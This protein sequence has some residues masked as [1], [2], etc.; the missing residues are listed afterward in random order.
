MKLSCLIAAI[1]ICAACLATAQGDAGKKQMKKEKAAQNPFMAVTEL[2]AT[3][4]P[5]SG[6][7]VKGSVYFKKMKGMVEVVVDVSGLTPGSE[8]GF[9]IHNFGNISAPDGTSAGDHYNPS[10]HP[11]GLPD[12]EVRHAGDFGNLKADDTGKAVKSFTIDDISLAG[13]MNP[14]IGRSIVIHAKKDD[15]GQ[16]TG[17]AGPRIGVGVIG[18]SKVKPMAQ[19][20]ADHVDKSGDDPEEAGH[21]AEDEEMEDHGE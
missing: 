13:K 14:I 10:G 19:P 5:A 4:V 2:V 3:V 16:P 1:G 9:H 11:H 7:N 12:A 6:S 21:N 17:N 8:H 20:T 15:G 18:V